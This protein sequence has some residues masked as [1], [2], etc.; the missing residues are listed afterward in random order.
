MRNSFLIL[1]MKH[2]YIEF[3][4]PLM[5]IYCYSLICQRALLIPFLVVC[6]RMWM[7]RDSDH[8]QNKAA[9]RLQIAFTKWTIGEVPYEGQHKY[10]STGLLF[11]LNILLLVTSG[12]CMSFFQGVSFV[13]KKNSNKIKAVLKPKYL[14]SISFNCVSVVCFRYH[15][16]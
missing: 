4:I 14:V 9:F 11:E 6:G 1:M 10:K 12:Y 13:L 15:Y 7:M 16:C 3:R 8:R 5:P 2:H